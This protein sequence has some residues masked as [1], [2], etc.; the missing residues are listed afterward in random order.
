MNI[1]IG[2]LIALVLAFVF[3][4]L[5]DLLRERMQWK[6]HRLVLVFGGAALVLGLSALFRM[7]GLP[8]EITNGLA[9][10]PVVG[11]YIGLQERPGKK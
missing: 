9:L 1:L 11:L 8:R 7:T 3:G 6:V 2:I 10:G 5:G 4:K